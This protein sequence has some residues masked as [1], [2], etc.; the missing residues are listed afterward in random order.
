MKYITSDDLYN[1][2]KDNMGKDY[3]C[4]DFR[5]Y[6]ANVLFIKYFLK[7]SKGKF[8]VK[9]IILKSIDETAYQL[10]HTRSISRKS[11]ISN[12]LIDYCLDSFESAA[13]CSAKELLCKVWSV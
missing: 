12:N 7:N 6:S 9:K 10:G 3:T 4:K 1:F 8:N 13:S 5:T 2:L 11:Y